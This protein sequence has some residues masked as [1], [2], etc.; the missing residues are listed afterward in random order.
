[1]FAWQLRHSSWVW[2]FA[3]YAL[4][5]PAMA[6]C[7]LIQLLAWLDGLVPLWQDWHISCLWHRWH[8]ARFDA[9]ACLWAVNQFDGCGICIPWH[10]SH[11][12]FEW[13]VLHAA[14]FTLAWPACADLHVWSWL[15]GFLV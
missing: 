11:D 13:Q 8:R 5:R 15:A 7:L 12:S 14:L 3:Q 2:Q 6:P 10:L 4:L 1:V 9:A